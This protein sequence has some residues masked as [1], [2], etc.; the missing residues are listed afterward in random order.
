MGAIALSYTLFSSNTFSTL[1]SGNMFVISSSLL[2]QSGRWI[3]M[4]LTL[5][6]H[7]NRV[8]ASLLRKLLF[9]PR[10][11]IWSFLPLMRKMDHLVCI[12]LPLPCI[13]LGKRL[14]WKT[15]MGIR[16][17]LALY[18]LLLISLCPRLSWKSRLPMHRL[19]LM[20]LQSNWHSRRQ[21]F[22]SSAIPSTSSNVALFVMNWGNPSVG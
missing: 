5:R 16:H 13:P 15:Y 22:L 6:F 1:H 21:V 8:L 7:R 19:L 3:W 18:L 11:P 12:A 17:V 20:L 9:H 14:A 4:T 10:N 2:V